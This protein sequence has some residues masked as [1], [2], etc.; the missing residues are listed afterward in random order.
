MLRQNLEYKAIAALVAL[1]I[2]F[3]VMFTVENPRVERTFPDVRLEARNVA[4]GLS[5]EMSP[6]SVRIVVSGPRK[7]VSELE[8][9]DARAWV[10][11]S[12]LKPGKIRVSPA[13]S[14]RGG[15]VSRIEPPEVTVLLQP[16][17][18][19]K[20][21]VEF[22]LLGPPVGQVVGRVTVAPTEVDLVGPAAAVKQVS[23]VV[24]RVDLSAASGGFR[25]YVKPQALDAGG[26]RVAG[27][28]LIPAR[29]RVEVPLQ[30]VSPARLMPIVLQ[31]RGR[32]PRGY[33]IAA[34]EMRPTIATV[35]GAQP[36]TKEVYTDA[37]VL[38]GVK[39]DVS[40]WLPLAVPP[41]ASAV[42]PDRAY[43]NL[44]I[45]RKR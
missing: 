31:T 42:H 39:K 5:S 4:E 36:G 3:Y 17:A 35:V 9:S 30:A 15:V 37:L 14:V 28:R 16:P 45:R 27:I 11:L 34:I 41:G 21:Q 6:P 20:R 40:T 8:S 7:L 25:G 29:V 19:G 33:E 43:V 12:G 26:Q 32:L 2:W 23:R 13:G 24:A 22:D 18:S 38:A 44:L 10:K 1:F